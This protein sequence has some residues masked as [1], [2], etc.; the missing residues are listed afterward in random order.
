[1]V[2]VVGPLRVV[3]E[4]AELARADDLR[5]VQARL[6]DHEDTAPPTPGGVHALCEHGHDRLGA[7]V[8]D[9]VDRVHAQA[10]D[11]EVAYPALRRLQH[12]LADRVGVLVVVVDRI[13]PERR[14]AV[15]E[16]RAERRQRLVARRA[17]VVVDD[18]EDHAEAVG[19]R[20]VD[21]AL[22]AERAAVGRLRGAEVDAVVAPA[23]VAG[24]LGDWHDLDRRHAELG[25]LRQ[26][27][28]RGIEGPLRRE[29][30][31]VQLVDDL[32]AERPRLEVLV[33]PD[34]RARVD[35]PRR[36]AQALG[37]VA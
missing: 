14:V 37:L 11:V 28:D 18:V 33:G 30:P 6:G 3:A 25:E 27:L 35:D 13:A 5:V 1:M 17:D 22:E 2:E 24:E 19:V 36:A 16:V 34:E 7:R 4:A 31:D 32:L 23:V 20:G 26:V 29:R 10:V 12:P 8:V 9:R 15:G 21:E